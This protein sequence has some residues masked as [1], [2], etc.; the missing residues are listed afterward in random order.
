M[1]V[2]EAPTSPQAQVSAP[3][4]PVYRH[5]ARSTAKVHSRRWA[6]QDAQPATSTPTSSSM[7]ENP[8][9]VIP[10]HTITA[11]PWKVPPA[12]TRS[13][14]A[15]QLALEQVQPKPI[16]PGVDSRL[17]PRVSPVKQGNVATPGA[18]LYGAAPPAGAA[19]IAPVPYTE[20]PTPN[21]SPVKSPD[22][23]L[24]AEGKDGPNL[25]P[26]VLDLSYN[27]KKMQVYDLKLSNAHGSIE[28]Q[29]L[30]D[31]TKVDIQK[32]VVL[33]YLNLDMYPGME[34]PPEGEGLNKPATVKLYRCNPC[35]PAKGDK[36]VPHDKFERMLKRSIEQSKSEHISYKEESENGV[37]NGWVWTFRV[38][39]FSR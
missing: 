1:V 7:I 6:R 3:P 23:P 21:A 2:Y 18:G 25:Q 11:P 5:T 37:N 28:F 15:D 26:K 4:R 10:M 14:D 38:K 31:L 12:N 35:N 33:K 13:A 8:H 17:G 24:N 16:T 39:N 19:N 36:I 22:P 27:N 32:T 30:T 34:P 9:Q 29:G 20:S